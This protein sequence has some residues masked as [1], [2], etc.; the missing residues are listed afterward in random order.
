M[1]EDSFKAGKKG[2]TLQQVEA[3][4]AKAAKA[5][6]GRPVRVVRS[7][8]QAGVYS[9]VYGVNGRNLDAKGLLAELKG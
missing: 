6:E 8:R 3:S 1:F 7:W 9:V 4:L 5:L 2:P